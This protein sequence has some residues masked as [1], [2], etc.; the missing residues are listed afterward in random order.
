M[1]KFFKSVD[2]HIGKRIIEYSNLKKEDKEFWSKLIVGYSQLCG[3]KNGYNFEMSKQG[4]KNKKLEIEDFLIIQSD[5]EITELL[6][7]ILLK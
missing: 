7:F 5:G 6:S 4:Q 3:L 2:Q 1:R